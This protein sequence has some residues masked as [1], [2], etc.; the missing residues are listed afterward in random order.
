MSARGIATTEWPEA[1]QQLM[2]REELREGV[3]GIKFVLEFNELD[4]AFLNLCLDPQ[5]RHIN[6]SYPPKASP[7]GDGLA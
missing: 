3:S 7:R 5:V 2:K 4:L 1:F 6:V